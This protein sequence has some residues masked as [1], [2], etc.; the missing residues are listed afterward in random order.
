MAAHRRPSPSRN[1]P[2]PQ[3]TQTISQNRRSARE[4]VHADG[5][6]KIK[7]VVI[8]MQ[9]N[10]SFDNYFGTFPGRRR[11]PDADTASDGV[12][13]RPGRRQVRAS[14]PRPRRSRHRRSA[15]PRQLGAD[16]DGGRMDGFIAQAERGG[17]CAANDPTA[18]STA[19]RGRC[20]APT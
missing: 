7:H 17:I 14:L 15:R 5:I 20:R 9:E 11:D 6:H 8:I 19:G 3:A 18:A 12:R 2:L 4:R 13:A 16:V 10:R 1:Q